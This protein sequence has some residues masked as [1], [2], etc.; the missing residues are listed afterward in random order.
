MPFLFLAPL[1]LAGLVA[2][3]APIVLH[4]IHK[5]RK[6]PIEFPSLMFLRQVPFKSVQRKRIRDWLLF[7]VRV[8]ALI[9][10]V[11]AFARPFV[12][13]ETS[14]SLT[15]SP[16][17]EVVVLLDRSYSMGY[18][19]RWAQ[20]QD[21][22][23]RVIGE[24][25]PSD[26]ASIVLFADGATASERTGDAAA[27]RTVV[28][29]AQPVPAVTRFGAALKLAQSVLESSE[30]PRREVV[31]ISDFQQSGWDPESAGRLPA[32]ATLTT[33]PI[34]DASTA[35]LSL[36]GVNLERDVF[37]GRERVTVSARVAN[38]SDA[39]ATVSAVLELNGQTVQTQRVEVEASG[40]ANAD[41]TPITVTEA[42]RARVRIDADALPYDD[43]FHFVLAPAERVGVVVLDNDGPNGA[44]SLYL[45]RA[46]AIGSEPAYRVTTKRASELSAADV[47]SARVVILNAPWPGGSAGERLHDFVRAGGGLVAVLGNSNAGWEG[48]AAELLPG[49]VLAPTDRT[50]T[51]GG[52]LGH[53]EFEHPV[54]DVFRS[55][56]SGDLGTARFYRYR[57]LE[58]GADDRVLA[59]FDDGAPALTEHTVGTG[60][61]L[62]WT[63]SLDT[64]WN[65][66]ALQPVFLPFVHRMVRHAA[67][68]SETPAWLTA[69]QVLALGGADSAAARA[70]IVLDPAGTRVD[71]DSTGLLRVAA[72][73]FY[74]VRGADGT[75]ST[76]AVAVNVD[77][78]E[79]DLTALDPATVVVAVQSTGDDARPQQA[80]A[81]M[82]ALE[83]RERRQSLWWYL[84]IAGLLLLAVETALA[85]R[86]SRTVR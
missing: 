71:V 84:L 66:L 42:Q 43:A 9:L 26:R 60:R 40:V 19:S 6:E 14:A 23:R 58:L 85:T 69:G 51:G 62:V 30:L 67:Q 33:I 77:L 82:I 44:S 57:P 54:F 13:R 61:V 29:S 59:R 52:A 70:P 18:G 12:D 1:F 4:L 45:R 72:P 73:G 39:A 53:I 68:Y 31:L 79:S 46:L 25:Q 3:A 63:S 34:G 78:A 37:E 80:G 11:G 10:L 28:D 5:E 50:G 35:N 21:A 27:L 49:R 20:A 15:L 64:Y 2:L 24:L 56:R 75:R 47:E 8:L 7:A 22:A 76:R 81:G 38:R 55:P 16:A 36:A 86:P 41:F 17:R 32:G 83:E 48:A 65:D 74:D